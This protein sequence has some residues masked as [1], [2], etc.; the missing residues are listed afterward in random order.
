MSFGL[1]GS[2]G[3][4]GRVRQEKPHRS[5]GA[6]KKGRAICSLLLSALLCAVVALSGCSR[7]SAGNEGGDSGTGISGTESSGQAGATQQVVIGSLATEDILPM[8]VA[9]AEGIFVEE[10]IGAT[11]MTF[12]SAQE[13]STA[14][15][16]GSV[17][18]AMTD[19]MVAATLSASGTPVTME[20]ITLGTSAD[21]G[22]FGIMTSPESGIA[23]LED[24]AGV[25]VG[26]GSCTV[27]EYVMD[28]LLE[29]AGLSDDEI[30][31]E[32]IKKLP[33]RYEMM[34]SNQVAAAALPASLLALGEANG[35]VLLADDTAG[36]NLSQSVM[37][38]REDTTRNTEGI[39]MVETLA[40]AWDIAVER[41]NADPESYRSLLVEKAQL[42]DE[43][44]DTYV[45][46]TYP[47][48]ERPRSAMVNPILDWMLEKGYLDSKL[49][50][51]YS[52][53]SF[54]T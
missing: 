48:T 18:M 46:S 42:A 15:V 33:V 4:D 37:I 13:L 50:Y 36:A 41:I 29:E 54:R 40:R 31:A 44:K 17:D 16:S 6:I 47:L 8:W 7:G 26:V 27:P 2:T 43:V 32:E 24:L 21:Q 5:T 52:A 10:G 53:G 1:S 28:K 30:V 25:P 14:V 11:V 34:A 22:R 38:V 51:D 12:Q 23:S 35:M 9:E 20:W 3:M 19:I 49:T 39:A 45:I